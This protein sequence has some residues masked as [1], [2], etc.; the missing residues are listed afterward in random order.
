VTRQIS[1]G[2][3]HRRLSGSQGPQT[4]FGREES[5]G[6]YGG[7]PF[8][9][10]KS[11]APVP[12]QVSVLRYQQAWTRS[13]RLLTDHCLAQAVFKVFSQHVYPNYARPWSSSGQVMG[14]SALVPAQALC[15]EK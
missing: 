2:A 3:V 5:G 1:E 4:P 6:G 10:M 8:A 14:R 7:F 15:S 11:F 12:Y 9:D 13:L